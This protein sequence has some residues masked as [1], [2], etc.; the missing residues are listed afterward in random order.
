MGYDDLGVFTG[1]V[2]TIGPDYVSI[3]YKNGFT[4][5]LD[6]VTL[7]ETNDVP[8]PEDQSSTTAEPETAE[9]RGEDGTE[10]DAE[11]GVG[12]TGR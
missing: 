6:E 8:A 5:R 11:P 3:N 10:P 2:T 1:T 7:Y 9:D 12:P 4:L